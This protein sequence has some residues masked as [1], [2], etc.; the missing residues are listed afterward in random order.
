MALDIYLGRSKRAA[1]R[2][3][4]LLALEEQV[5]TAL[6]KDSPVDWDLYPQLQRLG[7][8]YGAIVFTQSRISRLV[9]DIT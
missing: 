7:D 5:H 3:K 1:K 9:D 8:Y 2:S 6:F 4:R